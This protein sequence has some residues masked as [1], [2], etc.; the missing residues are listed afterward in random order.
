MHRTSSTHLSQELDHDL[1]PPFFHQEAA[2]HVLERFNE[3]YL[4]GYDQS[5]PLYEPATHQFGF[6]PWLTDSRI[7]PA[8]TY[9][10]HDG[11]YTPDAYAG[12]P[13][14]G[15]GRTLYDAAFRPPS[16]LH[17]PNFASSPDLQTSNVD[18]GSH[19][20]GFHPRA[21]W[22]RPASVGE[23]P[24]GYNPTV[25]H[26]HG[27]LAQLAT[28][29][30]MN[31]S[32]EDSVTHRQDGWGGHQDHPTPVSA[33]YF[34]GF[35]PGD[36]FAS[37]RLLGGSVVE[38]TVYGLPIDQRVLTNHTTNRDIPKE[39]LGQQ[40]ESFAYEN[41]F[42]PVQTLLAQVPQSV[43][44]Q[45]HLMPPVS[46]DAWRYARDQPDPARPIA[47]P[48]SASHGECVAG[49]PCDH[50]H[51]NETPQVTT[52]GKRQAEEVEE[53]T[54]PYDLIHIRLDGPFHEIQVLDVDSTYPLYPVRF[55]NT[56]P[57]HYETTS[58]SADVDFENATEASEDAPGELTDTETASD[59]TAPETPLAESVVEPAEQ[60]QQAEFEFIRGVIVPDERRADLVSAKFPVL[61][62]C[63]VCKA[64]HTKCVRTSLTGICVRCAKLDEQTRCFDPKAEIKWRVALACTECNKAKRNCDHDFLDGC[65]TQCRLCKELNKDCKYMVGIVQ[66][67]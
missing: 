54:Q 22:D 39:D 34:S 40:T 3:S 52:L 29:T 16:L 12:Q 19:L 67:A 11:P 41:V 38:D 31:P 21:R 37:N 14:T 32:R 64:K 8:T 2:P 55:V 65:R 18:I 33:E 42:E 6:E 48:A 30:S 36:P 35:H 23:M 49:V 4:E 13:E 15:F 62:A 58:A 47:L 61:P 20:P 10:G 1:I 50:H 56:F 5:Q 7:L 24:Y 9:G 53:Q 59:T 27:N 51:A 60:D 44:A 17:Q 63:P 28:L 46:Y 43:Q 25:E 57:E 26:L 45:T 66:E